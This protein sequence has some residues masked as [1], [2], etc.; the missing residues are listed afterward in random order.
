ML[1]ENSLPANRDVNAFAVG[2][3]V[4][5]HAGHSLQRFF[6]ADSTWHGINHF[7]IDNRRSSRID[8]EGNIQ[9]RR[10]QRD[11]LLHDSA[12]RENYVKFGRLRS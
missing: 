12:R 6:S 11:L 10:D 5:F 7:R 9:T 1:A 2:L 8:R 4:D 3:I